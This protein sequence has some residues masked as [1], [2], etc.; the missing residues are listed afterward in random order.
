M[1]DLVEAGILHSG[2]F[3]YLFS[4]VLIVGWRIVLKLCLSLERFRILICLAQTTSKETFLCYEFEVYF[5]L[6]GKKI[7]TIKNVALF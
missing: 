1:V 6:E 5:I 4:W 7:K 3:L 2:L